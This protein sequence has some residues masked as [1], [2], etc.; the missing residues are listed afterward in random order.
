MIQMAQVSARFESSPMMLNNPDY[1]RLVSELRDEGV[2]IFDAASPAAAHGAA[3][4]LT[5]DT[6]WTPEWMQT[7]ATDLA[8]Y[9]SRSGIELPRESALSLHEVAA[10]VT[11]TG[12]LVQMIKLPADQ[13]IFKAQT[14]TVRRV[15]DSRGQPWT[16]SRAAPVLV[17][18]DSFSNIYS[19]ESMAWGDSGGFVE[20]LSLA[21]GQPI[22]RMTRNDCG[23][24][25][26]REMLSRELAKGRNRLE[27]KKVVVWEF[28]IRELTAGDW[29]LL[30]IRL[31]PAR[32][33]KFF[34]PP[35]Q[36]TVTAT[37]TV[38]DAA[39]APRPGTVPYKDHIIAIHLVDLKISK[40]GT[41]DGEAIV[42]MWSMRN[43]TLTG[44]SK[45][46]EGD[47]VSLR[48]QPWSELEKKLG[49]IN[50]AD[51]AN[52]ELLLEEPCWGE[53]ATP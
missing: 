40:E 31:S 27:G 50:R 5:C 46:R 28:A 16:P 26:T 47:K 22:D 1:A 49:S 44:T 43:N 33:H 14:V 18:G 11:G 20:H 6:H 25:A 35:A 10:E 7:V 48:L 15:L 39:R 36:A 3:P 23:A 52:D 17:L 13:S 12:D 42:Y 38:A 41:E 32:P 51:L 30:D 34:V 4:F 24:H 19:L 9:I 37:G 53:E 45:Y 29:K 2:D 8:A 21:L